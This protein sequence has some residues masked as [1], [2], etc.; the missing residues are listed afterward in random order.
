MKWMAA[1]LV[2]LG[3]IGNLPDA[4]FPDGQ[5]PRAVISVHAG[6]LAEELQ[7]SAFLKPVGNGMICLGNWIET[8]WN[9]G[10]AELGRLADRAGT[11]E[12]PEVAAVSG[13][14][15]VDFID[16]GQ[17]DCTLIRQ[18][19]HAMLFDCGPDDKGTFVQNYLQ[20]QGITR[21][22]Y[23][24]GSHPDEDHIG[25]MDVILTKFDCDTVMLP[26]TEKDSRSVRD[27]NSALEYRGYYV[28][29]PVPG[30]SWQLGEAR[31]QILGPIWDYGTDTNNNS[32]VLRLTY[33]SNSFLFTGDAEQEEEQDLVADGAYL[34][35]DVY[36]AGH[37][38]SR[39]ASS[40]VFLEEVRPAF[41]VISCGAENDYGH[42]HDETLER[43]AEIGSEV[44]RT[45]LLGT[46]RARS[47]GTKL[48]WV[49]SGKY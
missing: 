12:E 34:K 49:W 40:G 39:N 42:P 2:L 44:Y 36:Q 23:V 9:R 48:S 29:R 22:D 7:N 26:E 11:R 45:D 19:E 15:T 17:G 16:V 33:G 25:G 4:W 47:D 38:G 14:L 37:H 1:V 6:R 3:I 24:I 10:A 30:E 21:L 35:S 28:T 20:K 13:E 27:V 41:T 18:G 46:V 31:F 8:V 32:I 43:L 5:S